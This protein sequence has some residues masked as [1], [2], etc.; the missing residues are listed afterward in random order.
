MC[1][2]F[3]GD[4][5]LLELR[6]VLLRYPTIVRYKDGDPSTLVEQSSTYAALSCP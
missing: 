2:F 1:P 3:V 5:M 6:L 4:T